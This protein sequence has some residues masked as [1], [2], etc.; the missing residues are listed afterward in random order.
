MMRF[1]IF[2]VVSI[3]FAG[4]VKAQTAVLYNYDGTF[5]DATF[6]IEGAI[7]G[8]GL[9]IDH[10][11]HTGEM[12]SRTAIDLGSDIEIFKA[13]DIFLFC[14]ATISRKVMEADPLNIVHCP[15]NIF[16]F[17]NDMGVQIGH[18]VYPDGP[19]QIVQELLSDII[20]EAIDF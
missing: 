19:M 17:E 6:S 1:L 14:S 9:V 2:C 12:L 3:F 18:R 10:I 15:Y 20:N 5:D 13:A 16:V 4:I 7:L 11:S 8:K